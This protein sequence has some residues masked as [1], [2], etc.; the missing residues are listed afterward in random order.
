[1]VPLE[2]ICSRGSLESKLHFR[3]SYAQG[4]LNESARTPSLRAFP[5]FFLSRLGYV[6]IPHSGKFSKALRN[7][8]YI[9]HQS[10]K[11]SI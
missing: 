3:I 9:I 2:F 10:M 8:L 1:M 6:E 11:D 4:Y 5:R 7:P